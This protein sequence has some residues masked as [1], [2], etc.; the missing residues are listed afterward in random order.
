MSD[1]IKDVLIAQVEAL[2]AQV[3]QCR[4]FVDQYKRYCLSVAGAARDHGAIEIEM[5]MNVAH[6]DQD[7]LGY[8]GVD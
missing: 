3:A 4:K 1:T 5:M 8:K 7:A 6:A 2:I